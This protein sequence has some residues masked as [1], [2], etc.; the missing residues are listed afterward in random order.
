V[1]SIICRLFPKERCI[2]SSELSGDDLVSVT[3]VTGN[4]R[5]AIQEFPV[6]TQTALINPA[7]DLFRMAREKTIFTAP[8]A[9]LLPALNLFGYFGGKAASLPLIVGQTSE[10]V[11]PPIPPGLAKHIAGI[12]ASA[13]GS[14]IVDVITCD[15]IASAFEPIAVSEQL[16]SP[17]EQF[18][19]GAGPLANL[20]KILVPVLIRLI[21][22]LL[23]LI[24]PA[25]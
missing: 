8:Q 13:T 3:G 1:N 24:A 12:P 21:P 7:M 10:S 15:E 9:A 19:V 20:G 23:R 11:A 22:E 4:E 18:V 2:M 5:Y 25:L 6:D 17:T 16:G 14:A